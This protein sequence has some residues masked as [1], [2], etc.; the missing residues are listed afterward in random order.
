[1]RWRVDADDRVRSHMQA[2]AA[3]LGR[4]AGPVLEGEQHLSGALS[5]V[6]GRDIQGLLAAACVVELV[7]RAGALPRP[8]GCP[9]GQAEVEG[10]PIDCAPCH[11]HV[12]LA[13][14]TCRHRW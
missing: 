3:E 2:L 11:R 5:R 9:T 6:G 13:R 8:R 1:M 7:E 12:W 14:H 4:L 10:A